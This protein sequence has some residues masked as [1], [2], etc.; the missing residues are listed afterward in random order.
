MDYTPKTSQSPYFF[1]F[2]LWAIENIKKAS[3]IPLPIALSWMYLR[4]IGIFWLPFYYAAVLITPIATLVL[5]FLIAA[6]LHSDA[7]YKDWEKCLKFK[8]DELNQSYK[9][10]KIPFEVVYEAYIK[11]EL[12]FLDEDNK[13]IQTLLDKNKMFSFHFTKGHINYFFQEFIHQI[14][15]HSKEIDHREVGDVYNRGND[16]YNYFLGETMIYTSGFWKE[17]NDTLEIAQYRKLDTIAKYIQLKEGDE[18]LDIGCGWGT[19]VRHYAKK[20]GAKTTGCTLAKEQVAW[21]SGLA[22]KENVANKVNFLCCDYREIPTKTNQKLFDKITC[23]EMAEHVG[24]KNFQNFLLQVKDMLK[25][26][27]I[28]YLQIAGLRRSWNW[29]D[30]VWGLFMSKYVFPGADAS[31]PLAFVVGHLERAGFEVHRVENMGVHYSKTIEAW[32]YNWV[33]N[34]EKVLSTYKSWWYRLWCMFLAWSVII[35]RQGTSTVFMITCHKNTRKDK[36]SV[37]PDET[38]GAFNR[39]EKWV[40]PDQVGSQQ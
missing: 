31:C 6:Y 2:I 25:D 17:P 1:E 37:S 32:F 36:S 28:F 26:D 34:K 7:G 15:G 39:I 29:E 22:E 4:D 14:T 16:F 20:Y 8:N 38:E 30:L 12:D 13:L 9:G 3:L 35:S 33:G 27:G 21:G 24:I 10:K 40:G 18:L 19:L 23:L 5:Y 11:S